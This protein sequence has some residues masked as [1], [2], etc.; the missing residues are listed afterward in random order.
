MS[1]KISLVGIQTVPGKDKNENLKKSLSLVDEALQSYRYV[2]IVVLP[3]YFHDMNL[4]D[5]DRY[6]EY[7]EDIKEAFSTRAKAYEAYILCGTVLHR[8]ENGK[9]YNTAILFD[10]QGDLVA[11]YDKIHLFDVLDGVGDE[12]ESNYCE[13]G[14]HVTVYD[15]DFGKIGITICYDVRFPE[16]ARTLALEGVEYLFT[17]AAFYSPRADHWTSLNAATALQNSMY[18][19]GVNLFGAWDENNVFCGRSCLVDPWGVTI[20]QASDKEAIIQAYVDPEYPRQIRERVGSFHNRVPNIY[21][22]PDI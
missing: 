6:Q 18:V 9:I 21:H 3:E 11:D 19:M 13:R 17:P 2:D 20:A 7:P 5:M 10:R 1:K 12:Q 22:I 16:L 15:T 14:D 4:A 8:R